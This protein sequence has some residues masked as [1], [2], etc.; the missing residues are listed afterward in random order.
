M[1]DESGDFRWGKFIGWMV[2][3]GVLVLLL[4]ETFVVIGSGERGVLTRMGKVTDRTYNEGLHAKVP[5][6]EGVWKVSVRIQKEQVDA[7]AAS[8]DL[9]E[10]S[11]TIALNY[12]LQ[13]DKVNWIFQNLGPEFKDRIIDPSIQESFKAVTAQYDAAQLLQERAIVKEKAKQNIMDRLVKEN[14]VVDDLSIVNFNFSDEFNKAI[15]AKQ[16]AQQNAEQAQYKL[17]ASKKDAEAIQVQAEALKS[18]PELVNWE[19]VKKWDGK[20]PTYVGSNMLP[21]IGQ[22]N[23]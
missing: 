10:V 12:H 5:F 15:E 11:S 23:K 16:V 8:K 3:I 18:N 4:S 13:P 7:S 20:M 9:Q 17:D 6:I 19:A 1:F 21:F 2:G 22:I 14:I